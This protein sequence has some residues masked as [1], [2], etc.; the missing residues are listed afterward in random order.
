MRLLNAFAVLTVVG[1]VSG[2]ER[3]GRSWPPAGTLADSS[4]RTPEAE[5]AAL[6][7]PPGFEVQLV[8]SEPDIDKPMNLAFDARGRLWV[9]HSREYPIAAAPGAGRDR[10]S[11]LEDTNADGRADRF[12]V[13]AD[14]LNIPIGIAPMRDGAIVY[15][16]PNLYRM[17]DRDGDGR[18]DERRVLYGPFDYDDTHGM[19]NSLLRSYDGWIHAGHGFS[20]RSTVA[21]TDG[22]S[23]R[24]TS[25]NTFRF[26]DDGSRVEQL[27]WGRVNPFGMFV[28]RFGYFYSSDSHTKPIYQPIRGAEYPHFGR[29]PSG[30][31]WG[32][33]MME[34]LHGSTAI[35][36][37]VLYEADHFPA[38]YRDNFFGGN[39]VTN[40]INRNVLRWHG[41]SPEAVEQPD[42]VVSDDP[43]FRPVD[44]E[45]GPDGALYIADF[46]NP[47]IGHYEFPLDDPRRDRRS[48]RIWRI[49]YA[50]SDAG[51]PARMPRR[52]WTRAT[53]QELITDLAHANVNVRLLATNEL[54]DR[55]GRDVIDAARRMID[56]RSATPEQ[57][58]SGL[59]ILSRLAALP[60][61][62][63]RTAAT[64]REELVRV[65]A[66]RI[67]A[68]SRT[69]S[70]ADRMVAERGLRDASPHVRRV[71]VEALGRH[72]AWSA[73]QSLLELRAAVPS[74]DTHLLYTVR[75][76]L[77]DHLRDPAIF[78]R[79]RS[80]DWNERDARA[81]ADAA[82][83]IPTAA[84]ARLL[85]AHLQRVSEP[86]ERMIHY[87][88]HVARYAP[89]AELDPLAGLVQ[90]SVPTDL[91][92]Q[93]DLHEVAR[94]GITERGEAMPASTRAW[95]ESLVAHYLDRAYGAGLKP[96]DV[97]LRRQQA[98]R[99]AGD[100]GMRAAEPGLLALFADAKSE[101]AARVAAGRALLAIDRARRLALIGG[102]LTDA[103]TPA[104]MREELVGV[105]AA[106]GP[107]GLPHLARALDASSARLRERIT[108]ALA[109]S[110]EGA[111]LV[112]DAVR[113]GRLQ[114]QAIA[115]PTLRERLVTGK[116]ESIRAAVSEVAR[117]DSSIEAARRGRIEA[118]TRRYDA[119]TASAEQG[120]R[121]FT[122]NCSPCHSVRGQGGQVG[123]QLDGVGHRTPED[124]LAKVLA[125]NRNVAPAFRY[126]TVILKNGD[127]FTGLYRRE[128]GVSVTFVDRDGK[129]TSVPKSQIAQR[130]ITPYTIMPSNF[131]DVVPE[132]ELHHLIAYLGTLR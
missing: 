48:G 2:S 103:A 98:A 110:S 80:T 71:A 29:L 99:I 56:R 79:V 116:P 49:V 32:P 131:M 77:R 38:A 20:N 7:V 5:R 82:S 18:A 78:D 42:F 17:I 66:L 115:D 21:G 15:S 35:A 107:E 68:E 60:P 97:T 105:L 129:E 26:R 118:I 100:L 75:V 34:H 87:L 65:H 9:T 39:V 101:P 117:A 73:V 4:W 130:R 12:T 25:G 119:R 52:D 62:R 72:P 47:I 63:L 36:G 13:F 40:R 88:R 10:V 86:S 53:T 123:P 111:G 121:V 61:E 106:A 90:R 120:A 31:G 64:D 112:I 57:K 113:T 44:I 92:L 96:G 55:G 74:E 23:I 81:V 67:L 11:I 37:V 132:S 102:A 124:L 45:L 127:V 28:D 108:Y 58:A 33:Q 30:I 70:A 91:D 3:V 128:Q 76:A 122:T 16:I 46:Y 89:A 94:A 51:S 85:L 27:T 59:W 109:G 93:L 8:A 1:L 14:S 24:M 22:D 41:S 43:N 6:H 50:G 126:E 125:P 19:V 83:G 84:A 69:L 114:T 104:P 54:V 95:S